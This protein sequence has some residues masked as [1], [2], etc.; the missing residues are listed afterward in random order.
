MKTYKIN[1]IRRDYYKNG[2]LK[3]EGNYLDDEYEGDGNFIIK[4]EKF[5]LDNLKMG[6]KMEMDLYLRIIK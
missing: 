4:M 2:N 5:I 1:G 6:K 3:C